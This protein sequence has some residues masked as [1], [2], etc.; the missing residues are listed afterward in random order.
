MLVRQR[1]QMLRKKP[2]QITPSTR[3]MRY[4]KTH[5]PYEGCD[6]ANFCANTRFS[7]RKHD[8]VCEQNNS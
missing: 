1:P 5:L 8:K 4:A 2:A 7:T 3:P 6:R